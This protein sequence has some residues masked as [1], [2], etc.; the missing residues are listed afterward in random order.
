LPEDIQL[1]RQLLDLYI[2]NGDI[3]PA[4]A[5]CEEL[6]RFTRTDPELWFQYLIEKI[7]DG[8]QA[9]LMEYLEDFLQEHPHAAAMYYTTLGSLY[10]EQE[11][12]PDAQRILQKAR[13]VHPENSRIKTAS[14]YLHLQQ[15]QYEE[16]YRAFRQVQT[17]PTN[18]EWVSNPLFAFNFVLAAQQTGRIEKAADALSAAYENDPGILTLYLRMLSSGK[19]PV[20]AESATDLLQRF[21]ERSPDAIHAL[22][23]LSYLLAEQKQYEDALH[24]A[25][26]F[27]EQAAGTTGTNLLDGAFYY[28]YAA[29]HERTGTLVDAEPLFRKAIELGPDSVAAAA[30][31]YMAYMWAERGDKLDTA[32]GLIQKAL[33]VEPENAAFIDTLGWIYYMQGRYEE[34]LV[35]LKKASELIQDDP[36]VWEHLGDTYLKLGD[37]GCAIRKWEKGLQADPDHQ[38]L[39]ERLKETGISTNGYPAPKDSPADTPSR[40]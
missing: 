21:H 27:E 2:L 10:I 13:A 37:R 9:A 4:L 36:E 5:L 39:I 12:I 30:Q 16:A 25:K 17:G 28:Q 22:Y 19:P 35:Q 8:Q 32:L 38:P 18:P 3:E 11:K 15:E 40:P 24:H 1:A 29:L 34:A 6:R 7:P 31:N 14:G 23:Y 26:R 33:A 20:S